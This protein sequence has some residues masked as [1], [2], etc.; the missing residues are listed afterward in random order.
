MLLSSWCLWQ[1]IWGF[2]WLC[3]PRHEKLFIHQ[4]QIPSEF[5]SVI[6]QYLHLLLHV[7]HSSLCMFVRVLF[8]SLQ[9]LPR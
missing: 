3:L 2:A 4:L 9:Q 7:S 6:A 1:L 8:H 5:H